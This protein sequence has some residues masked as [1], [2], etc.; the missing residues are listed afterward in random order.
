[1]AAALPQSPVDTAARPTRDST[2]PF[3][4]LVLGALAM[5]ISP[6]FVRIADVGPLASAF[7]RV[8]AALPVLWLWSAMEARSRGEPYTGGGIL[9]TVR[10]TTEATYE[11]LVAATRARLESAAAGGTTTIEVKSGYGLTMEQESRQLRLI[12]YAA[13]GLRMRVLRT[14]LGAHAVPAGSS[15]AEQDARSTTV[16]TSAAARTRAAGFMPGM[17]P[18][19]SLAPSAS[20]G[21]P[22]PRHQPFAANRY[23]PDQPSGTCGTS[24]DA[25]DM[26]SCRL[27]SRDARVRARRGL[28]ARRPMRRVSV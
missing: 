19:A 22:L 24:P 12:A 1:M 20:A 15:P 3:A 23:Q 2:L 16:A 11:A 9:R 4:A 6:T 21:R 27:M 28:T 13:D 26:A 5:G 14:Y 17:M 8:G 7:W 25:D 18:H 10:A